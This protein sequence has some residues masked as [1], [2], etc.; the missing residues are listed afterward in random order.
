MPTSIAH[1]VP[2]DRPPAECPSPLPLVLG[3]CHNPRVAVAPSLENQGGVLRLQLDGLQARHQSTRGSLVPVAQ[4][5]DLTVRGQAGQAVVLRY[6]VDLAYTGGTGWARLLLWVNGFRVETPE[7]SAGTH[8]RV[9]EPVWLDRKGCLR[10]SWTLLAQSDFEGRI[11]EA[12]IRIPRVEFE[13]R[14]G[15]GPMR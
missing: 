7:L 6:W 1:A 4:T 10:A 3:D 11:C 2:T 5:C 14:P 12:C 9:V 8:M 15:T 13:V